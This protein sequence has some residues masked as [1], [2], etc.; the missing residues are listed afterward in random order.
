LHTGDIGQWTERGTLRIIDRKKQLMKL[1]Q[2]EYVSPE[3]IETVYAH[4]PLVTQVFVH[5]DSLKASL[6]AVVVPDLE[7]RA[8]ILTAHI[9]AGIA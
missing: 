6:V 9:R 4:C 5:G 8:Y 7:V 2:G 3:K 1:A